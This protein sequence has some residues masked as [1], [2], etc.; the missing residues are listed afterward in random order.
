MQSPRLH[1]GERD[2]LIPGFTL[3][4][5]LPFGIYTIEAALLEPDFGTTL[6]RQSVTAT[7]K[8]EGRGSV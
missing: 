8:E 3:P 1:A 4:A 5:G 6:S 2:I 7:R